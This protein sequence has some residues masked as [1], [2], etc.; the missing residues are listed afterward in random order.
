MP[1]EWDIGSAE[2]LER[3]CA[4]CVFCVLAGGQLREVP[5]FMMCLVL[6][7]QSR[8][9]LLIKAASYRAPLKNTAELG[10]L[11]I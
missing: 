7:C 11:C 4:V 9:W 5:W 3:A 6:C 8:A 10:V 1:I 2:R